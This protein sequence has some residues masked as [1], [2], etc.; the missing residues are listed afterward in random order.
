MAKKKAKK[1]AKKPAKGVK[2]KKESMVR[3]ID[4]G[5]VP[6]RR[7]TTTLLRRSIDRLPTTSKIP[8][9]GRLPTM[10]VA[11][12]RRGTIDNL[13]RHMGRLPTYS[14]SQ[15][16]RLASTCLMNRTMGRLPTIGRVGKPTFHHSTTNQP[17]LS[18]VRLP[19]GAWQMILGREK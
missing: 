13:H 12:F 18:T 14:R 4:H 19:T 8:T 5:L 11:T 16:F 1:S 9:K 17:H 10:G 6:F 15:T 3:S 7:S 2:V